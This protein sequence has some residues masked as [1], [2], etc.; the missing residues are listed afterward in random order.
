[1]TYEAIQQAMFPMAAG[2]GARVD[3]EMTTFAGKVH[4]DNLGRWYDIVGGQLLDP[5]FREED[6]SRVRSN[7]VNAIRV[8]L[9]ANN[10]EELGNEVLYERLY[11]GH[12]YGHMTRGHAAAVEK[13]NL[14][15][16]RGFHRA[17]YTQANLIMAL[18]GSAEASLLAKMRND[19]AAHLP[20]GQPR[21][22]AIPPARALN[23]LDVTLVQK[24]VRAAAI[25]MGF[26]IAVKRGDPDF[27]PLYLARS[28]LGEHRNSAS[29]LYQR[30]R[31]IRGM[32]YG[33][34]AYTEYFPGGMFLSSPQPG[35]ARSQQAFR[36]WIRPVPV[37]QTHFAIRIAKYELDKLVKEGIGQTDFD[38]TKSFLTKQAGLLTAQQ[39][40][41]LGYELDQGFYGAPEFVRYVRTGLAGLTKARVDA[42]VRRHLASTNMAIVVVTP[43]A[44]ALKAALVANSPSP[45]AYASEKPAAILA[46]D[47]IVERYPLAIRPASVR[48][49]PVGEVFEKALF[50]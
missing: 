13:I 10:D 2:F 27:I 40:D 14:E 28:F 19:L 39:G 26:P 1:M 7:L 5:G 22:R 11:A 4:R 20:A 44:E 35:V 49:V 6:F 17:H 48:I 30:M 29:H 15:D 41:R 12:P 21:R 24:D 18:A 32:N 50:A 33:D 38:A 23:G 9:R 16:V 42:A 45:I 47:K 36:I 31:E 37:E 46:E 3:Q 25:S 8:G 43:Q 34:Y